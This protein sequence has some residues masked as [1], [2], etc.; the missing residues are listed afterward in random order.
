VTPLQA[1]AEALVCPT[2]RVKLEAQSHSASGGVPWED[3]TIRCPSGCQFAIERGIP[4]FVDGGYA[5]AFGL[6]WR[7]YQRIQLD[8]YLGRTYSRDRLERCLGVPL[9][10]LAGKRVLEVGAG[11][12]RFTEWLKRYAGAL[13]SID[14]SDAVDANL[15][16]G[17]GKEP[18]L[19]LQADL[20]RSPLPHKA[21]DAVVCL[22]VLQHTPS[23]EESIKNLV[24]H[25]APGG[26][27]AIDH[28]RRA[29]GLFAYKMYLS[30]GYPLRL[31]LRDLDPET[32]LKATIAITRI[33]DPVRKWTNKHYW[34][35]QAV[36]MALPSACYYRDYPDLDPA[37]V[38][39]INELDT[40]DGLTD[41]YKHRR[42]V[43]EIDA[44]L[45]Q[46][47]L[48]HVVCSEGGNG[49]E[50]HATAPVTV[51]LS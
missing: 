22:G 16:N 17:Q 41:Y 14:L 4:R 29:P 13:V 44:F 6:Q 27:L 19:L 1:L 49:V 33:C 23:P 9:T 48:T 12:G 37:L 45:R 5:K 10:S 40:H 8:S 25:L 2:H 20:S 42:T 39:Q 3:G 11:A 51:G 36:S 38:Y 50:A 46:I 24:A 31:I 28:Y 26:L 34:L 30:L 18:Y 7:R 32:G 43:A 21:F 35:D 47:G 15:L